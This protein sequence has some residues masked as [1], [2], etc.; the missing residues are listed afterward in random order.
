MAY[1]HAVT[2]IEGPYS[3]AVNGLERW[4]LAACCIN[5]IEGLA[6]LCKQLESVNVDLLR[7]M[8]RAMAEA[9]ICTEVDSRCEESYGQSGAARVH[10][11]NGYR[12]RR[13]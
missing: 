6:W 11:S 9:L 8:V 3:K 13:W 7:E 4:R 10:H 2:K 1:G 5:Q 12:G